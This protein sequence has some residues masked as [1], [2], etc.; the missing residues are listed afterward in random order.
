MAEDD[1]TQ[2]TKKVGDKKF[3][4]I[5]CGLVILFTIALFLIIFWLG[6][7]AANPWGEEPGPGP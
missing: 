4:L 7:E 2:I 6:A 1:S 5:G 3:I